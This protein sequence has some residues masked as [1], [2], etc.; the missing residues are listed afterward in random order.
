MVRLLRL[1]RTSWYG[2]LAGFGPIS[3]GVPLMRRCDREV[4]KRYRK[5]KS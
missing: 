1:L 3:D 5:A 2:H 4:T